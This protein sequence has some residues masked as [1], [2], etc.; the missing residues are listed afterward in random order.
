MTKATTNT[1]KETDIDNFKANK[2]FQRSSPIRTIH[3][4]T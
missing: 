1:Q 4:D 3:L 2:H